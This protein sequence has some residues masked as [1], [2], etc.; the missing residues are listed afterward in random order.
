LEIEIICGKDTGLFNLKSVEE[1]FFEA[2]HKKEFSSEASKKSFFHLWCGQYLENF[3]EH[4]LLAKKENVILGYCCAHPDSVKAL[5]DFKVPGQ[6]IFIEQF[7]EF[8]VHLHINCHEKSRGMGVGRLLIEAQAKRF[9]IGMHIVTDP[10]ADNYGF[11]K[12][13]GFKHEVESSFKGH[14]LLL[15]GRKLC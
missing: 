9:R 3:P 10:K 13:L 1:I 15:M 7:S 14:G 12:A 4:F 5:A 6:S 11:Y 2:S 8:P